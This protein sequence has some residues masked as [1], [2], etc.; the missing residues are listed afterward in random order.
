MFR[1][2]SCVKLTQHRHLFVYRYQI[3][4]FV[5]ALLQRH[6]CQD[7]QWIEQ[8]REHRISTNHVVVC[9]S[10]CQSITR[11]ITPRTL[12]Y[13]FF[14]SFFSH[15]VDI[16]FSFFIFHFSGVRRYQVTTNVDHGV[17]D[18]TKYSEYSSD[19][20]VVWRRYNDFRWLYDTL[21]HRYPGTIV[22]PLPP[23]K[24]FGNLEPLFIKERQ[25]ELEFFLQSVV[26]HPILQKSFFLKTFLVASR[27]G[28]DAAM[29]MTEE[30]RRVTNAVVGS[31]RWGSGSGGRSGRS[32]G[33]GGSG[34][35]RRNR[36]SS[37]GGGEG[38]AAAAAGEGETEEAEAG[39]GASGGSVAK[40]RVA[41]T[42][43]A[44]ATAVS[45][46]FNWAYGRIKEKVTDQITLTPEEITSIVGKRRS[47]LT[48]KRVS[49]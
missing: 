1:Y 16:I 38:K 15:G 43:A 36:T 46:L 44:T 23:T 27:R 33:S 28:L 24:T 32:G 35:R 45:G 12:F 17:N 22:P 25:A 41:E 7:L 10:I 9:P 19:D 30:S 29:N 40:Q 4:V 21:C 8:T 11:Q 34:G 42:A 49:S 2:S 13:V 20:N 48:Y 3:L 26:Q 47:L 31:E 14:S 6:S 39:R 37:S 18:G 5:L